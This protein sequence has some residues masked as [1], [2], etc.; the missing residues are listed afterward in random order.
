M[1]NQNSDL[2]DDQLNV[3]HIGDFARANWLSITSSNNHVP[4]GMT[5]NYRI[6]PVR[7]PRGSEL[8]GLRLFVSA[9]NLNYT[10]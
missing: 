2:S 3:G 10:L 4:S 6:G 9:N 1:L 8:N 7:G 5:W